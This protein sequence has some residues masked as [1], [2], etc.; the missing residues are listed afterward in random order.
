M[1]FQSVMLAE[2]Y[3]M[4]EKETGGDQSLISA[5]YLDI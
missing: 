5:V 1:A 4:P 2:D 3:R